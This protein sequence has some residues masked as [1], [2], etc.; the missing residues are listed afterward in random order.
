M[1]NIRTA[2]RSGLVLR[3][4]RNRRDTLWTSITGTGTVL[5]SSTTSALINSANAAL[6]ALTPFT[7]VR[8]RG[9][10]HIIS[11]QTAAAEDQ[12]VNLSYAIVSEQAVAIGVSAV[13]TPTIDQG[14]DLFFVFDTLMAAQFAGTADALRGIGKSYDSRAMRK[15]EEGQDIAVVVETEVGGVT[16]GLL[17]RHMG[18]ML[19]KLH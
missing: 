7:V 12:A 16:D 18:R 5:A 15:V 8:V 3:G 19:I 1:A 9:Y 13:P 14:S 4:G 6:L 17:V 2:R 10:F 11:D